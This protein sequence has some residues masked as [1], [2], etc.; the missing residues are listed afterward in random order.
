M[1]DAEKKQ[2]AKDKELWFHKA[3]KIKK[4]RKAKE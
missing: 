1:T 4:A 3:Q 2:R